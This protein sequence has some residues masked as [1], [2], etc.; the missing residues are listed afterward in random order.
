MID[1]KEKIKQA[2]TLDALNLLAYLLAVNETLSRQARKDLARYL[3]AKRELL[4]LNK[5]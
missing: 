2:N 5:Q 1:F 4:T 3:L